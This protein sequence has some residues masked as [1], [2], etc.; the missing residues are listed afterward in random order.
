MLHPAGLASV[1][2]LAE[3]LQPIDQIAS[4]STRGKPQRLADRDEIGLAKV[5]DKE[6][7]SEPPATSERLAH[8]FGTATVHPTDVEPIDPMV[9][10]MPN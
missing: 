1:E 4:I 8:L 2:R 6:I 10:L 3:F 7:R 5:I 9:M